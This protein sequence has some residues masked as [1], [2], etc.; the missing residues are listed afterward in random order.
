MKVFRTL[1]AIALAIPLLAQAQF[2][3][4]DTATTGSQFSALYE[5]NN[6]IDGSGLPPGFGPS[7]LHAAYAPSNHWTTLAG[8]IANNTAWAEFSFNTA[9][10]LD[11]FYLWNHQSNGGISANLHYAVTQFDLIFKD[12]SNNTI[13]S[14]LDVAAVG[15]PGQSAA[16]TFT[17]AQM[18]GVRT[19]RFVIDKNSAPANITGLRYT[20]VAEVGFGLSVTP[21]P[22]PSTWALLGAGLALVA[23][24]ARRRRSA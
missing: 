1:T 22:E 10:T 12:G 16:Q 18:S 9:K 13:G 15:G 5:V 11:T 7:S 23:G 17:F 8:A 20:G 2:F 19:V 4:A 14:V 6:A 24:I 21:V 3:R